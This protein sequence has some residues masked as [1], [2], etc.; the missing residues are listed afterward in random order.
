MLKAYIAGPI[1]SHPEGIK[2]AVEDFSEAEMDLIEAGYGVFNPARVELKMG[3]EIGTLELE[4]AMAIELPEVC[5]S[6]LIVTLPGAYSSQG[7]TIE[8]TVAALLGKPILTLQEALTWDERITL[9]CQTSTASDG[10]T[11]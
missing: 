9:I 7:A 2:A 5:K 3:L 1:R 10:G 4:E 11:T 6:D 8:V